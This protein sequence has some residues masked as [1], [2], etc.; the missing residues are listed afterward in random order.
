MGQ[1]V[2]LTG[3][4]HMSLLLIR[5]AG[6]WSLIVVSVELLIIV[7]L[8]WRLTGLAFFERWL[9]RLSWFLPLYLYWAHEQHPQ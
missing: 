4:L 1:N 5:H 8:L 3:G 6:Y 7:G 9:R 2:L